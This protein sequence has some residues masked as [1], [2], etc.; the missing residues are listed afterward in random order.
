MI[1]MFFRLGSQAPGSQVGTVYVHNRWCVLSGSVDI[2][3]YRIVQIGALVLSCRLQFAGVKPARHQHSWSLNNFARPQ[4]GAR[5][6]AVAHIQLQEFLLKKAPQMCTVK[7][8]EFKKIRD[9]ETLTLLKQFN[10]LH[11]FSQV[12][13]CYNSVKAL[14]NNQGAIFAVHSICQQYQDPFLLYVPFV[15]DL[16]HGSNGWL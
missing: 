5:K 8:M 12:L 14:K 13:L 11:E 10:N 15:N 2:L 3:P 1:Y 16:P 7:K 4:I 6:C 9:S